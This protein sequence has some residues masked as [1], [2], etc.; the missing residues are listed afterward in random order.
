MAQESYSKIKSSEYELLSKKKKIG[1]MQIIIAKQNYL[2]KMGEEL[3]YIDGFDVTLLLF[4]N[5]STKSAKPT[6]APTARQPQRKPPFSSHRKR[7]ADYLIN[8]LEFSSLSPPSMISYQSKYNYQ[9]DSSYSLSNY[10]TMKFFS[11]SRNTSGC[12]SF[13]CW[14]SDPSD[15]HTSFCTRRTWCSLRS[16]TCSASQCRLLTF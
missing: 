9:E 7:V 10:R 16:G 2:K 12:F 15:L 13:I 1:E 8:I 14:L 3:K 11:F 5:C 4:R 6:S